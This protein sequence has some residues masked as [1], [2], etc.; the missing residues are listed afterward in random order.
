MRQSPNVDH[1]GDVAL[2]KLE[3]RA[4]LHGPT[5]QLVA[6]QDPGVRRP[7]VLV[8]PDDG[9]LAE[10]ALQEGFGTEVVFDAH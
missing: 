10:V 9:S 1:D 6:D 5:Q 4:V 3:C 8:I 7:V 2:P